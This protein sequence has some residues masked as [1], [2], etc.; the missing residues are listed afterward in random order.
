MQI[1]SSYQIKL[2]SFR[3]FKILPSYAVCPY[4]LMNNCLRIPET[5]I[6]Q[7]LMSLFA[8]FNFWIGTWLKTQPKSFPTW[9]TFLIHS[10][11]SKSCYKIFKHINE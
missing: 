4:I 9:W 6:H 1:N 3:S 2:A 5:I 11:I 7:L 10:N 8:E